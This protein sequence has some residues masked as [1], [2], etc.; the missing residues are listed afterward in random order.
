MSLAQCCRN[1]HRDVCFFRYMF[2]GRDVT[3]TLLLFRLI[4]T[5]IWSAIETVITVIIYSYLKT[6]RRT[7]DSLPETMVWLI[8]FNLRG[9]MMTPF[10]IHSYI[11]FDENNRVCS[12]AVVPWFQ[13]GILVWFIV[14][15]FIFF[16]NKKA[17]CRENVNLLFVYI[18]VLSIVY[19][20]YLFTHVLFVCATRM[21]RNIR[22]NARTG[23]SINLLHT[24]PCHQY[25]MER[26]CNSTCD[27][28]DPE[29][30]TEG[31][32]PTTCSVCMDDFKQGEMV[33]D[34][35]CG[36]SFHR[37]CIDEW[38]MRK[39]SCPLCRQKPM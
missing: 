29:N 12:R 7:C 26:I 33:R 16:L 25:K 36:H 19:Y 30:L 38:L 18:I 6:N 15:Q 24:I 1:L 3:K 21:H 11:K 34:L 32:W 17:H 27:E 5:F 8:I 14:G 9:I 10:L 31:N 20:L 2:R 22:N 35:N 13:V 23:L 28:E 37:A 39:S 4:W